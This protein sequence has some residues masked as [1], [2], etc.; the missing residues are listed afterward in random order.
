MNAG[1]REN[2][3][4]CR[5][6]YYYY[7]YTHTFIYIWKAETG[8]D[9]INNGISGLEATATAAA[10]GANELYGECGVGEGVGGSLLNIGR[11]LVGGHVPPNPRLRH[12]VVH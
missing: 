6:I 5:Y 7:Y 2:K 1:E 4:N 12:G 9:I 11:R 8:H 3:E 10:A